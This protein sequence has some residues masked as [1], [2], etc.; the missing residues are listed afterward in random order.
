MRQ[1][2]RTVLDEL[3]DDRERWRRR[4]RPERCHLWERRRGEI[5]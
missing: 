2:L 4:H 3:L 5:A 1:P